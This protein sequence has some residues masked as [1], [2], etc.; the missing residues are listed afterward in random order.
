[1][2]RSLAQLASQRFEFLETVYGF[3]LVVS[4]ETLVRWETDDIFLQVT[5]DATRSYEVDLAIGQLTV[6][7]ERVWPPFSLSDL[8]GLAG[9]PFKVRPFFQASTEDRLKAAVEQI[10]D[11][12]HQHGKRFLANDVELFRSLQQQM[13]K[14]SCEY[15]L[16]KRLSWMR[17]SAEKAWHEHDYKT[18][19]DLYRKQLG[20]LTRSEAKRY[21][22]ALK[23][24]E[25]SPQ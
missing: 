3:R 5:Y 8:V 24:V 25:S 9:V 19:V 16:Q 13:N 22:I 20:N 2:I 12:F 21:K 4:S 14:E 11:L 17:E 10:A 1:M 23:H 7:K 15:G 6:E 18:V